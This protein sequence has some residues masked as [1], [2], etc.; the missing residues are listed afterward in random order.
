MSVRKLGILLFSSFLIF[1]T[2]P[3]SFA[4]STQNQNQDQTTKKKQKSTTNKETGKTTQQ[5]AP[6]GENKAGS[7]EKSE[8]N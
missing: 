1:A 2:A 8:T 7:N 3:L 4:Q 5:N 6:A